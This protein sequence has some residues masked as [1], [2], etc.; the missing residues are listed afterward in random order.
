[1]SKITQSA[2]NQMCAV[3]LPVCN[4]NP[5]TTVWSHYNGLAGGKGVG[6]KVND[7]LGAYAC[8]NCHGVY[9]RQIP[10]PVGMTRDEIELAWWQGH[11]R[12]ICILIEL[13]IIT[14]ER[15]K[16]AA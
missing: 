4:W 10:A 5:E 3:R 2:R 14:T 16:V 1:M 8:F 13:G 12:S 6:L 11:A 9:D 7:L 15:G